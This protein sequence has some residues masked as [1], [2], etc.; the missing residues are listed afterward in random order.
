[1]NEDNFYGEENKT[2][3]DEGTAS[4]QGIYKE[5]TFQQQGEYHQSAAGW[6][7]DTKSDGYGASVYQGEAQSK[8][9]VFGIVSMTLGIVSLALF[10]SCC[11]ILLAILAIIF[12]I[13]QLTKPGQQKGMAIAGI[14]TAS[15]SILFFAVFAV[16]MA[17]ST[18]FQT[19]LEQGIENGLGPEFYQEFYDS[20][21][22]PNISGDDSDDTF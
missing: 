13:L 20:Y 10:C 22:L 18:D 7:M 2:P 6:T 16:M 17:L 9:P 3:M 15:L 4:Q 19:Q 1:M 5:S 8:D 14:V 11:N 21:N 12:G